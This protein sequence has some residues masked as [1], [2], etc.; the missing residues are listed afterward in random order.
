MTPI[1]DCICSAGIAAW[2]TCGRMYRDVVVS[3]AWPIASRV[4]V[5]LPLSA[6]YVA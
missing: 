4:A 2:D 1:V 6:E 3:D 5:R